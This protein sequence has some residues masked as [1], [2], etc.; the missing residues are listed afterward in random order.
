[1]VK[2]QGGKGSG[3]SFF[4]TVIDMVPRV[5]FIF[6]HLLEQGAYSMMWD[7]EKISVMFHGS[8]VWSLEF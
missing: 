7:A 4:H 1:M 8:F 2:F 5:Y 3:C 6:I